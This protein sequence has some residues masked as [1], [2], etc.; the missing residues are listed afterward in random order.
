MKKVTI[1]SIMFSAI[2]FGLFALITEGQAQ[3]KSNAVGQVAENS[4]SKQKS[5]GDMVFS[6]F[7]CD[8]CFYDNDDLIGSNV[9]FKCN[10]VTIN[11]GLIKLNKATREF[12][13]GVVKGK[14]YENKIELTCPKDILNDENVKYTAD[15]VEKSDD[16]ILLKGNARLTSTQ[17]DLIESDEIVII[18]R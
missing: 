7:S 13:A 4:S 9:K 10:G 15:K 11:L 12:N 3:K 6:H 1:L 8:N 16:R 18:Y 14:L 2:L 17:K 5:N